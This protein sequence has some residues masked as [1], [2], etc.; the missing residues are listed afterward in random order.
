MASGGRQRDCDH[1]GLPVPTASVEEGASEQ[2]CCPACRTVHGVIHDLGLEGFYRYREL[3]GEE[4]ARAVTS[5]RAYGHFDD[6]TFQELYTRPAGG[7]LRR[8]SLY[9]EGVHCGG[10]VW[11]VERLPHILD[12]VH[13]A[14][15]DLG[16]SR[17]D[18]LWDPHLCE[19]SGIARR[20][21]SLGYPAHAYRHREAEEI[22]RREQRSLLIRMAVSGA[23]AGNVMLLASALYS[24][25]LQGMEARFESFFRWI[26]LLLSVP[27][28]IWGGGVFLRGAWGALKSRMLHIDLPISIGI[29]TGFLWGAT[30]TIRGEGQIYFDSVTLLIF[31]LLAGRLLQRL[32]QRRAREAAD[33]L[34]S[35]TPRSARRIETDGVRE[36]PLEVLVPGDRV[37]VRSGE[38]IPGD[39]LVVRGRTALD[40]SVLTGEPRPVEVEEGGLVSAG[41]VNVGGAIDVR[42]EVTGERTRV[43]QILQ[44]VEEYARRRAP[45]LGLVDRISGWF[46]AAVIALAAATAL[47][48]LAID[49]SRAVDNAVALLIVTCPCALG[50]ATPLAVSSALGQAARRGVLIKGGDVFERL[51]RPGRIWLDKTGTITTGRLELAE[52]HGDEQIK[53][54]VAALE[55]ES[56]HPLA[57]AFQRATQAAR[58]PPVTAVAALRGGG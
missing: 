25:S 31:L 36:V 5:G 52:W 16:R 24:G 34:S 44:M 41:F 19:L 42:V 48:W 4:R 38:T 21:D 58:R 53:D 12:G 7:G 22:A 23:I 10:C 3:A 8:T 54:L 29:V 46:V 50:L 1:C 26:S 35:F 33:L 17:V 40:A 14:R 32:G 15:L 43:G 51:A 6:A 9:L 56:S 39:G 2:F 55:G 28:V 13:Q 49:P 18:L 45:I 57:R 47:L 27:V 11:L 37:R 20:L 30:N